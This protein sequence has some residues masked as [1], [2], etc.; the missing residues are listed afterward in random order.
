MQRTRRGVR[1]IATVLVTDRKI[2]GG[3]EFTFRKPDEAEPD[4]RPMTA[5]RTTRAFCWGPDAANEASV[6]PEAGPVSDK[7]LSVFLKHLHVA[8]K[9]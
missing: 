6:E 8:Y 1:P 7:D 5:V 9:L 2:A 4:N 3:R